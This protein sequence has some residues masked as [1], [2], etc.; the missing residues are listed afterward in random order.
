MPDKSA[1]PPGQQTSLATAPGGVGEGSLFFTISFSIL[2]LDSSRFLYIILRSKLK[3]EKQRRCLVNGNTH[4]ISSILN[5]L[6]NF[7][8]GGDNDSHVRRRQVIQ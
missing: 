4:K 6:G 2:E 1:Q 8:I 7:S 3:A 5:D